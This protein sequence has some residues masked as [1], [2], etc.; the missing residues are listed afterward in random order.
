MSAAMDVNPAVKTRQEKQAS[1]L[2]R[3]WSLL[4]ED[5]GKLIWAMVFR[6]F[7]SMALGLAYGGVLWVIVGIAEGREVTGAWIAQVA[8]LMA[9]SLGGQLLFSFLSV[10]LAWSVSFETAGQLRLALL[11]HLQ[12]LPLGFH[13]SRQRGDMVNM[14]TTDVTMLEGFI[15]DALLRL[16]QAFALPLSVFAFMCYTDWRLGLIMGASIVLGFPIMA[17]TSRWLARLGLERQDKQAEASSR[18]IE[19]VLGI[20]VIRAFG[21]IREG[22]ARF[23]KALTDFRDISRQ[24]VASLVAP[25]MLFIIVVMLGIPA[26]YLGVNLFYDSLAPGVAIV[27]LVLVFSMYA[28]I[29]A[30]VGVI[31]LLRMA[32]ASMIRIDRMLDAEPLPVAANP[33]APKGHEVVFDKVSFDYG[34]GTPVVSNISFTVPEN[35]M[36]AIV[37]HSGSG[38]STLLNLVARFWDVSGGRLKIGGAEVSQIAPEVLQGLVSFVFQDVYLFSG[39]I[40]DNIAIGRDGATEE[41]IVEAAKKAQAHEFILALPEGYDTQVGEGGARISGGE[42]QRIAIAR[43]IIKDAPIVLLDEATAAIDPIN[44][45]ALQQALS[46]LVSHRSLIVV[47]HKL[48]T[49]EAAD[50]IVVLDGGRIAEIGTHETLLEKGGIYH[51][52]FTRKSQAQ[53]WSLTT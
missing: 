33:V 24:M 50:Q 22:N 3:L 9:L 27:V 45:R 48:S 23:E 4:G 10:R 11:D 47:A 44:E 17:L 25:F 6:V 35:T 21:R 20:K 43:A 53:S 32:D 19:Y 28:P 16:V 51:R 18:M 12:S 8:G 29:S 13:L 40:R 2:P 39:T 30:F 46:A 15:S 26:T 42:R 14:L 38:K 36:T 1:G 7:Q 49:I 31:E 34:T 52:L 5:R 41:E 37:G